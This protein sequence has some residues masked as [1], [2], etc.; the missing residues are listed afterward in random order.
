MR[1]PTN[2]NAFS[3]TSL[4]YGIDV[5]NGDKAVWSFSTD[6]LSSLKK[7]IKYIEY[8]RNNNMTLKIRNNFDVHT[9]PFD[10]D[11]VIESYF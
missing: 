2:V 1:K 10:N 5:L 6:D 9:I 7:Q 8:Y 4:N 3:Q 11:C